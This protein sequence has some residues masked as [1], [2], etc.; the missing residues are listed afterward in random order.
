MHNPYSKL[1]LPVLCRLYENNIAP[2]LPLNTIA[3]LKV[4]GQS[5]NE[6]FATKN[7][8]VDV[9]PTVHAL[10]KLTRTM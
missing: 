5:S 9:S 2:Y 7:K 4:M 8:L 6:L 3:I 1:Q 10:D